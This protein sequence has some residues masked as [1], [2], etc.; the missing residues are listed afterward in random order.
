MDELDEADDD[1]DDDSDDS[2]DANADDADESNISEFDETAEHDIDSIVAAKTVGADDSSSQPS[3]SKNRAAPQRSPFVSFETVE[4]KLLQVHKA[5]LTPSFVAGETSQTISVRFVLLLLC[6]DRPNRTDARSRGGSRSEC[7]ASA[8]SKSSCCWRARAASPAPCSATTSCRS[9][10][11]WRAT[12]CAQS[13]AAHRRRRTRRVARQS[14]SARRCAATTP[15]ACSRTSTRRSRSGPTTSSTAI[16]SFS[17]RIRNVCDVVITVFAR[18]CFGRQQEAVCECDLAERSSNQKS[19]GQL[20]FQILMTV[21][22]IA[23]RYSIRH[24]KLKVSIHRPTFAEVQ[25]V[26]QQLCLLRSMPAPSQPASSSSPSSST[27]NASLSSSVDNKASSTKSSTK[28]SPTH[29]PI[30]NAIYR[31]DVVALER[32]LSDHVTTW[33]VFF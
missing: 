13:R 4:G 26:H 2:Q 29:H 27:I 3:K 33:G 19:A 22:H 1:D 25:R 14:R 30:L 28:S 32:A 21:I 23:A 12:R 15:C 7:F 8:R 17:V 5:L 31:S 10:A 11:R 9:I 16:C 24:C 6:L 20:L 18:R